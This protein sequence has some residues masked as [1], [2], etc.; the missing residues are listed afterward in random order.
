MAA[1]RHSQTATQ[2]KCQSIELQIFSYGL[3]LPE[4]SYTPNLKNQF[5]N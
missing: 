4:H 5:K 3:D 1:V 2:S